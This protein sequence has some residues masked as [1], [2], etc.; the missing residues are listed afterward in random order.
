MTVHITNTSEKLATQIQMSPSQIENSH[1]V[2]RYPLAFPSPEIII[3]YQAVQMSQK[4]SNPYH[5]RVSFM[6][7]YAR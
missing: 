6:D 1:L 5:N 2:L 7:C 4:T 3:I